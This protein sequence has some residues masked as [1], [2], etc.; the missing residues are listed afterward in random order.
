[1]R[2]YGQQ[3]PVEMTAG[4]LRGERGKLTDRQANQS[5]S[6]A[7]RIFNFRTR[8]TAIEWHHI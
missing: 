8:L 3:P 2:R 4:K 5:P 7:G 6:G 1:M